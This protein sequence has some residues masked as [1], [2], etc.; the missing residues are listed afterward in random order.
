MYLLTLTPTLLRQLRGILKTETNWLHMTE[1]TP[2]P[3]NLNLKRN[4]Y[5][6]HTCMYVQ[7]VKLHN[8][9]TSVCVRK[10]SMERFRQ[11]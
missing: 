7:Y 2:G 11:I 1:L 3:A 8:I 6:V 10:Y 9:M 5:I 4:C